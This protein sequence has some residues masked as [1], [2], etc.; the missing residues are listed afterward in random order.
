MANKKYNEDVIIK[1]FSD[2]INSTYGQ[3]YVGQNNIQTIDVWKALGI[4][5]A[6]CQGNA[7]KYLMRYGKKGGKNR[8][9]LLKVLHYTILMM[10]FQEEQSKL[11]GSKEAPLEGSKEAPVGGRMA[12][13]PSV[14]MQQL[15]EM[16]EFFGIS[17]EDR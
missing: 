15:Q 8:K 6:N 4:A 10:Y 3:H 5:E 12:D 17:L 1:E 13:I 11:E 2:Y 9:D 16:F 7:I 14:E